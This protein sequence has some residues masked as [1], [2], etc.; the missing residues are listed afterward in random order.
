MAPRKTAS[1]PSPTYEE[2]DVAPSDGNDV[3]RIYQR[4]GSG[5]DKLS[6]LLDRAAVNRMRTELVA[7][8]TGDVLEVAVGTGANLRHYPAGVRVTGLDFAA[9]AVAAATKRAGPL[10]IEWA[11]VVGDAERIPLADASVDTVV[12]TLGACTFARPDV[13]FGEMRRVLRPGGQALFLEHVR[14]ANR[15]GRAI[16]RTITP[17]TVA[18]LGCHPDR[19][20]L[21]TLITAG[22]TVEVLDQAIG[23]L[24]LSLRTAPAC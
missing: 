19:D 23:G 21:H 2:D 1:T 3:A 12:C 15:A 6:A 22:F 18:A 11:P 24:F 4:W 13:V 17:L 9:K 7:R 5:Y 14:A 10:G 8:A 16:L 20:T